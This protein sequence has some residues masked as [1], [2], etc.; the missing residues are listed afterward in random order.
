MFFFWLLFYLVCISLIFF[1]FHI[2]FVNEE[3]LIFLCMVVLF[4]L[5]FS[6]LRRTVNFMFFVKVEQVYFFFLYLL[7]LSEHLINRVLKLLKLYFLKLSLI[8]VIEIGNFFYKVIRNFL[9]ISIFYN[10]IIVN[11]LFELIN[12]NNILLNCLQK[13]LFFNCNIIINDNIFIQKLYCNLVPSYC[14]LVR[15]NLMLSNVVLLQQLGDSV[16]K[17]F[18]FYC[19]KEGLFALCLPSSLEVLGLP[20]ALFNAIFLKNFKLFLVF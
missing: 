11:K 17:D 13:S 20:A 9:N 1:D 15:N 14:F 4:I 5:L 19:R 10:L 18:L 8:F 2:L 16:F 6:A 12:F 7:L 3:F